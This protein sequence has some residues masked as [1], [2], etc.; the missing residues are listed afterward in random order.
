MSY[1]HTG[2]FAIYIT[3]VLLD[4]ASP[5]ASHSQDGT[6]SVVYVSEGCSEAEEV[7]RQ[8]PYLMAVSNY[9][10]SKR[11]GFLGCVS[12]NSTTTTALLGI[13]GY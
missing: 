7:A 2:R 3:D 8:S 13:L 1:E 6:G 11:T 12:C 5:R 10:I 9:E 4:S